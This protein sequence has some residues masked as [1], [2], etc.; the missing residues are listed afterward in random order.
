MFLAHYSNT[1]LETLLEWPVEKLL[2]WHNQAVE[3]YNELKE[4]SQNA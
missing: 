2:F 4:G 1:S 3:L